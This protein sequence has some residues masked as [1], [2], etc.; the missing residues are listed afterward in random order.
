[1]EWPPQF[2]LLNLSFL[3]HTSPTDFI[4]TS[5]NPDPCKKEIILRVWH[6]FRYITFWYTYQIRLVICFVDK[7]KE[8]AGY[9]QISESHCFAVVYV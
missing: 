5:L 1:M 8:M 4:E 3:S 7:A 6:A 9:F 2:Q